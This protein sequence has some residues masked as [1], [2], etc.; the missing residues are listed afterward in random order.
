MST[1]DQNKMQLHSCS[2]PLQIRV[3]RHHFADGSFAQVGIRWRFLSIA[4]VVLRP[5]APSRRRALPKQRVVKAK[6]SAA[7]AQHIAKLEQ[8]RD[9]A[10]AKLAALERQ[11]VAKDNE[12]AQLK[13]ELAL[14]KVSIFPRVAD[15]TSSDNDVVF[16]FTG[17]P[18]V[19]SI[20]L[21]LKVLVGFIGGKPDRGLRLAPESDNVAA[22]DTGG[23]AGALPVVDQLFVALV[24][25]RSGLSQQRAAKLFGV[26]QQTIGRVF[27]A[28]VRWMAIC[29]A[30]LFPHHPDKERRAWHSDIPLWNKQLGKR[31]AIVLDATEIRVEIPRD[32]RANGLFY[33]SYKSATT[34]KILIGVTPAGVCSFVSRCYPGRITDAE[35]TRLSGVL[36]LLGPGDY[37]LVDKGFYIDV[38]C[39]TRG[40][41]TVRPPKK[42]NNV[43]QFSA[44]ENIETKKIANVRIHIER[45][46]QQLKSWHFLQ[47]L[48]P[49]TQM[50][51]IS[52]VVIAVC[53]LCT[54]LLPPL[55]G[56]DFFDKSDDE[57]AK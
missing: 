6:L 24:I 34:V 50:H 20:K 28:W 47:K 53:G 54:L 1:T 49:R 10:V 52:D 43:H 37:V 31:I 9:A 8:E 18:S 30:I 56:L 3:C 57:E 39:L 2:P 44:A 21:Y 15:M 35:I 12:I 7:W 40:L 23:R 38:M 13:R 16:E 48:V 17:F 32:L 45:F 36:D 27:Q 11:D 14:K 29:S 51:I 22:R 4:D 26:S 25:L 42:R 5:A 46:N 33:S 41:R 55:T 19:K